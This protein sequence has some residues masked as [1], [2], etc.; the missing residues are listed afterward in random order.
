MEKLDTDILFPV[1]PDPKFLL[2]H[3]QEVPKR[4][5][6]VAF[7]PYQGPLRGPEPSLVSLGRVA[8]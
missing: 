7:G 3:V 5:E 2:V 6:T 4:L 8:D 1:K